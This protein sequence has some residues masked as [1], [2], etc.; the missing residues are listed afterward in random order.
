MNWKTDQPFVCLSDDAKVSRD[1]AL[2]ESEDLGGVTVN[3]NPVPKPI[4][5]LIILTII[6]AFLVTTPLWGQRPTAGMYQGYVDSMDTPE[7][8]AAKTDKEAME[9]IVAMNKGTHFDALLERH[10][11]TMDYLRLIRPQ[12]KELEQKQQS[13][14][15]NYQDLKD[16]EVVGDKIVKANFEGNFREDGTRIRQQ[17]SWDK[18]F[19]IDVFYVSYFLTFVFIIIKRLPPT[20]WQPKHGNQTTDVKINY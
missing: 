16:Y 15:K 11:V 8:K 7:V 18:G 19:T 13:G 10:P 12:E 20:T 9:K 3:N 6:T 1:K 17:P 2:W 5:G 14:D 4:V